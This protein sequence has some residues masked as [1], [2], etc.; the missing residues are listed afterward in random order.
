MSSD[1]D[2]RACVEGIESGYEYMLAYAA[3]GRD[4]EGGGASGPSI[5][6]LLE[7][8]S[9]ALGSIADAVQNEIESGSGAN[10][11]ALMQYAA[12]LA[13]DAGKAKAAVDLAL[14]VPS[15][16][17]QIIDNLNGSI[18]LRAL[19]TSIFLIDEALRL[20]RAPA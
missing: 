3:Q 2:F 14:S 9:A 10:A 15:I 19:L 20:S 17:S 1:L 7:T 18:H 6:S 4:K 13:A 16:G 5:R 12:V 8:L 11:A